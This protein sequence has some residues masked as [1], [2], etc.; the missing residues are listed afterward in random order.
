MSERHIRRNAEPP[1]KPP[2]SIPLSRPS[3]PLLPFS[4]ISVEWVGVSCG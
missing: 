3:L 1:P 4:I 2:N